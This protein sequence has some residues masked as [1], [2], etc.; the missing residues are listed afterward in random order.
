MARICPVYKKGAHDDPANYRPISILCTVSKL[1]ERFIS[2]EMTA[3]LKV[4]TAITQYQHGFRTGFST[5][6]ALIDLTE[7]IYKAMESGNYTAAVLLDLSRAFDT[8]DHGILLNKLSHYGFRG[9]F[10]DLIKFYLSNRTFFV[11]LGTKVSNNYLIDSGVPQG[12]ILGH[13]CSL[14]T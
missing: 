13:Y 14:F 5:T 12:S 11:A 8:V 1:F 2:N 6:T 4:N 3:F 10:L 9:S 7:Y